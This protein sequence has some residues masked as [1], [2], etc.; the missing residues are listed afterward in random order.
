MR[1][2]EEKKATRRKGIEFINEH[3]AFEFLKNTTPN[4]F[5][6]CKPQMKT[7]EL[8]DEQIKTLN[9]FSAAA[10]VSYY[11]A[12]IQRPDRTN[13]LRN[14]TIP[15]LFI[16]GKYDNAVPLSDILK[17]C[18]LPSLSY[19]HILEN[20]GHMGMLEEPEKANLILENFLQ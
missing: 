13:I 20:S 9:N 19:I 10:L 5:S 1:I 16:A 3:G 14:S 17:Q 7:P 6:P 12:M 8:I 11:E 15:V 18:H 2:A 4:L